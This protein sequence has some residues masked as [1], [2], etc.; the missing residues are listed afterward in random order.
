MTYAEALAAGAGA[1]I[2]AALA[3]G[4]SVKY[5]AALAASQFEGL[6]GGLAALIAGNESRA[7]EAA[8]GRYEAGQDVLPQSSYET[9][10]IALPS[11]YRYL[12]TLEITNPQ[13]GVS[14]YVSN[15]I[16]ADSPAS[17]DDLESRFPS[18]LVQYLA[19]TGGDTPK[20]VFDEGDLEYT[21]TLERAQ[22]R[23][24]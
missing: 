4:R 1:V 13:T 11:N 8:V 7:R 14:R 12:V 22:E 24:V 3:A 2:D 16:D 9:V 5:A 20:I 19:A 10:G 18:S 15:W 17:M 23:G 6:G 21:Y